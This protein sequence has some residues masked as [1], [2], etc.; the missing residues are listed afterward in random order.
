MFLNEEFTAPTRECSS[1]SL[2]WVF[3]PLQVASFVP[4]VR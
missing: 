4:S 2:I 3:L 1:R